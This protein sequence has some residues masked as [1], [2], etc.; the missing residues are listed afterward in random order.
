MKNEKGSILA[1][2]V[3][4]AVSA[5]SCVSFQDR[6]L[7]PQE[8]VQYEVVGTVSTT[9]TSTQILHRINFDGIKN[10]AISLLRQE[11]SEKY[12]GNIDIKNVVID[13]TVSG[14]NFLW[15]FTTGTCPL[16]YNIQKITAYGDVV[17]INSGVGVINRQRME[18]A[19][20][21]ISKNLIE[22]LPNNSTIAV[23]SISSSS[24]DTSEYIVDE[25][26]Y[27]LVNSGKF[28][29]VDRRRLDQIRNEQNFQMSG[30]VDDNSAVSIG[31][32]LG[33][34]IVLTGIISNIGATQ[35]ISI[36]ALDVKTARIV[37]IAREQ[38]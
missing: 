31:N 37:T 34:N 35:I 26:E 2:L 9:F 36:K 28:A 5:I 18:N 33:A 12:Q 29:I 25:L 8:R 22:R 19:L 1:V 21:D 6:T 7:E 11:A 32:M 4:S 10:K 23:L 27:H 17:L 3:I 14:W 38:I 20:Q 24:R 13:G 16:F 30:D 15:F